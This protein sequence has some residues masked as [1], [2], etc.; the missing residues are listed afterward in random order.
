MS[1]LDSFALALPFP[2][3]VGLPWGCLEEEWEVVD[4][5]CLTAAPLRAPPFRFFA[6]GEGVA[7]LEG[8]VFFCWREFSLLGEEDLFEVFSFSWRD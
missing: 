3:F 8:L 7:A 5:V 1:F 6:E 4:L 2:E